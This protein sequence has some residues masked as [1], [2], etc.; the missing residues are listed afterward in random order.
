MSEASRIGFFSDL[1]LT[2][3][4]SHRAMK[5]YH[6]SPYGAMIIDMKGDEPMGYMRVHTW[7]VL[8]SVIDQGV[9]FI[10]V[11][12]RTHT[13]YKHISIPGVVP[14]YSIVLSGA[15]IMENGEENPEWRSHMSN[16]MAK[17]SIQPQDLHASIEHEAISIPGV[18]K[19]RCAEGMFVY[20][21]K[22]EGENHELAEFFAKV[23]RETGYVLSHQGRKSYLVPPCVDKGLSIEF[24]KD[25]VKP[26][27]TVGAGDSVL[28]LPMANS[29]DVFIQPL[30]GEAVG[31][32]PG[33][34][35]TPHRGIEAAGDIMY[36]L[37]TQLAQ[38]E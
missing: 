12:T 18:N 36:Y 2:L 11:T 15:Q 28:D 4:Y 22:D 33:A 9:E 8:R 32:L 37:E 38:M 35:V 27:H 26:Q 30:H 3:V 1:D 13:Q 16:E 14:R 23:Q 25:K 21:I 34:I 17:L 6:D 5:R 29:V 20:A 7:E 19:I 10:P 31:M 24:L